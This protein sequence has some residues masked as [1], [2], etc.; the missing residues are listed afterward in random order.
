[1]LQKSEGIAKKKVTTVAGDS[2]IKNLNSREISTINS[3][4]SR[5]NTEGTTSNQITLASFWCL[6]CYLDKHILHLITPCSSVSIDNFEQAN[7]GWGRI[8][9]NNY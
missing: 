8:I 4:K 9:G 7:A 2:I 6:Y 5:S 3:V 1:M